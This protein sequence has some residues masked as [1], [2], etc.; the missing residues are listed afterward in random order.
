MGQIKVSKG[1]NFLAKINE[2]KNLVHLRLSFLSASIH[3]FVYLDH[4]K[5][6]AFT[7]FQELKF[8]YSF[9]Y[10]TNNLAASRNN[11]QL[12]LAK[13]HSIAQN[14]SKEITRAYI[15]TA[16]VMDQCNTTTSNQSSFSSRPA[17]VSLHNPYWSEVNPTGL[18]HIFT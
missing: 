2:M 6:V 1:Q 9:I 14:T 10:T 3:C 12:S 11:C 15:N 18:R 13:T 16:K 17:R 7:V 8:C 4:C 5:S